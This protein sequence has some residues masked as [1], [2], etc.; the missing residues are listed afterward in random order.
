MWG[1][2]LWQSLPPLST[3]MLLEQTIMST[4]GV[5]FGKVTCADLDAKQY[6]GRW[7]EEE[8]NKKQKYGKFV[9]FTKIDI[10]GYKLYDDEL[11]NATVRSEQ[12]KDDA[13]DDIAY[14]Y[15]E[16]GWDYN[17]FPPIVSTKGKI[18]DGRT[19]I[20]AALVAGWKY[21]VVAIFSYDDEVNEEASDIV[22]GLLA[23]NHLVARRANMNDIVTGG[24]V[25]V[26]KGLINCDQ[27]SI[28]DWLYNEVEIERF[29]SNV[30]G[31]IT[32]IS[33]RILN[34]STP[35]GD[36]IIVDKT[37]SE[38]IEYLENCKEVKTLGVALPDAPNPLNENQL[39]FYSTG[40]TNARRCWVDQILANT[41]HGHHTYIVLYST[42]KTA[43]KL[44]EE[45]KNFANDLEMFYAQTVKLINSQLNGIQVSLPESRPFT[46]IGTIPQFADDEKHME[47][48]A[49]TRLIPLDQI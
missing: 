46:I 2:C 42:D 43:E 24:C 6:E 45:L 13:T 3:K 25:M 38:W 19:R 47:L 12:N 26:S 8:I 10:S 4:S 15:E 20:R 28:D 35:D 11:N 22:N 23:N 9:K 40:K 29:Y 30:A 27:A 17:P 33:K 34:E 41:T 7:S 32:K 18:K 5:G 36:P 16:H 1:R 44:R 49:M 48:R 31:T 21:I 39:V 14:S 37:R